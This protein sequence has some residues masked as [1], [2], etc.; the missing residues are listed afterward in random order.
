MQPNEINQIQPQVDPQ[1]T[2]YSAP[3][4]EAATPVLEPESKPKKWWILVTGILITA[5]LCVAGIFF[6]FNY[7]GRD[8]SGKTADDLQ[9]EIVALEEELSALSRAEDEI[10]S[11]TGFSEEF[12]ESSDERSELELEKAELEIARDNLLE[13]DR[14]SDIFKTGAAYFFI[15]AAIILLATIIAFFRL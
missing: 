8:A 10:F 15:S 3:L 12:F 4:P 6:Q 13:S 5:A 11:S 7:H 1:G 2:I 9:K 14:N